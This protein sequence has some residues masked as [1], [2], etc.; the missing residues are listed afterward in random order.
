MRRCQPFQYPGQSVNTSLW[1]PRRQAPRTRA[2]NRRRAERIKNMR[3]DSQPGNSQYLI[4]PP[5]PKVP[6]ASSLPQKTTTLVDNLSPLNGERDRPGSA[7]SSP[8]D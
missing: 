1:L 2:E 3:R 8:V 7:H 5:L 4:L 6:T